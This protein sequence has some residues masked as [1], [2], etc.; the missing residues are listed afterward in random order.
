MEPERGVCSVESVLD[1]KG[2]ET[3]GGKRYMRWNAALWVVYVPGKLRSGET[4]R[5]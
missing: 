4:K 5:R 2:Q 1:V 3:K